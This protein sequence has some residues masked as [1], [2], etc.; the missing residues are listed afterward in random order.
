MRL[1]RANLYVNLAFIALW[2]IGKRRLIVVVKR[3]FMKK[4][5]YVYLVL[6]LVNFANLKLIALSVYQRRI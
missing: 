3:D 2:R 5:N 1:V 4:I 6:L